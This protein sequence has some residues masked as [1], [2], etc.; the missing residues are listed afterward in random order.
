MKEIL[1]AAFLLDP[2]P[3]NKHLESTWYFTKWPGH[4]LISSNTPYVVGA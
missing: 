4:W 2:G 1:R 3:Y